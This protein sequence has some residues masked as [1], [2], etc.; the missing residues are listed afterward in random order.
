MP[1]S[2]IINHSFPRPS[3][4]PNQGPT[5]QK[6]T[7]LRTVLVGVDFKGGD[8]QGVGPLS[9]KGIEVGEVGALNTCVFWHARRAQRGS[10]SGERCP[11]R[12]TFGNPAPCLESWSVVVFRRFGRRTRTSARTVSAVRNGAWRVG[13]VPAFCA[14]CSLLR[15][16]PTL[17]L[18]ARGS[19]G[20]ARRVLDSRLITHRCTLPGVVFFFLS[21]T[22]TFGLS[23]TENPINLGKLLP[24]NTHYAVYRCS[25]GE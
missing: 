11:A 18:S 2:S 4:T 19:F 25:C 7:L 17:L 21:L 24:D 8:L 22:D 23:A 1:Y 10:R 16:Q 13:C 5:K 14:V 20:S 15:W 6:P 12:T 3:L 9:V